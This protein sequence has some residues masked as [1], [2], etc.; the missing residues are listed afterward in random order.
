MNKLPLPECDI[1]YME[2]FLTNDESLSLFEY[3]NNFNIWKVKE[4]YIFG[5]KC[6]QNRETCAFSENGVNYKYNGLDNLGEPI[7]N[8]SILYK[9]KAKLEKLFKKAVINLR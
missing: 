8:D 5:R 2:N 1:H 6:K 4:F 7:C 3:L 9:V